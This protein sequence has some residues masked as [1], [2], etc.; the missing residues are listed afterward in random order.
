M[1]AVLEAI[2][3][4]MLEQKVRLGD[5]LQEFEKRFIQTALARSSGNQCKAAQLLHVHRNTLARKI[6]QYKIKRNR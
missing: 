2:V 3:A 4:E 6:V 1:K 5:A